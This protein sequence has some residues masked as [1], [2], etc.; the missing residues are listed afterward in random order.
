MGGKVLAAIG[1]SAVALVV[2][3]RRFVQRSSVVELP[4]ETVTGVDTVTDVDDDM[5]VGAPVGLPFVDPT[6]PPQTTNTEG[7]GATLDVVI[8]IR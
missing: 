8:E 3:G 4:Q 1:A 6:P 2:I 5:P 7:D